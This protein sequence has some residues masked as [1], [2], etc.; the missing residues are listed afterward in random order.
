MATR[1]AIKT[2]GNSVPI[3]NTEMQIDESE[4]DGN[5]T[6]IPTGVTE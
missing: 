4:S 3:E 6:W 1:E 5:G 2:F